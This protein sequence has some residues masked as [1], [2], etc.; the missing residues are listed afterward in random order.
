MESIKII[1]LFNHSYY[2][3]V[4][5]FCLWENVFKT[6][7]WF[8]IWSIFSGEG[9]KLWR[10][11][12]TPFFYYRW[13]MSNHCISFT[14][15]EKLSRFLWD[16]WVRTTPTILSFGITELIWINLKT[17]HWSTRSIRAWAD[18]HIIKGVIRVTHC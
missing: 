2:L 3:Q 1:S 7:H 11:E 6:E 15:L 5:L 4:K 14:D 16:I 18:L 12:T 10:R 8:S 13:D 9:N 17:E